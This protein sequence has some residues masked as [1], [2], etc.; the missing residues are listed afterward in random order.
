MAAAEGIDGEEVARWPDPGAECGRYSGV[1]SAAAPD[2]TFEEAEAEEQEKAQRIQEARQRLRD[3]RDP[4]IKGSPQQTSCIPGELSAVQTEAVL[5]PLGEELRCSGASVQCDI[6]VSPS[7]LAKPAAVSR[8][9][10][11]AARLTVKLGPQ[12]AGNSEVFCIAA[13]QVDSIRG[14]VKQ[15][16]F[17]TVWGY[18]TAPGAL[19][20]GR[21]SWSAVQH[22][23]A[24][25]VV[26]VDVVDAGAQG[27]QIRF[28]VDG[29]AVCAK[30]PL[31]P[32]P[33]GTPLRFGVLF[34]GQCTRGDSCLV[35][36]AKMS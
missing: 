22:S 15:C 6:A 9:I 16:K 11:G 20:A 30:K 3:N 33:V 14:G 18:I 34:S 26:V 19:S 10:R 32:V 21:G 1:G 12:W 28:W 5:C 13:E 7:C 4:V 27:C 8:P 24:G 23:Q 17:G 29:K 31:P 25:S 36:L 2:K 35:Q